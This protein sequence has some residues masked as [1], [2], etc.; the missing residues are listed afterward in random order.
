[1]PRWGFCTPT[2]KTSSSLLP[3]SSSLS[4]S[5][6]SVFSS[7]LCQSSELL[8]TLLTVSFDFL[9][10]ASF[11]FFPR[12]RDL[13]AF[14]GGCLS[15]ELR[16]SGCP[17]SLQFKQ[18][19]SQKHIAEVRRTAIA[20]H[21]EWLQVGWLLGFVRDCEGGGTLTNRQRPVH[22]MDRVRV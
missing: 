1:M 4:M 22:S 10:S 9:Q 18:S 3:R 16:R 5:V 19:R 7:S 13:P 17:P 6:L 15:R 8:F 21:L 2:G 20:K 11:C 12:L 14:G